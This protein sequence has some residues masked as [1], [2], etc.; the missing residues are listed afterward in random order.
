M[1]KI[2][3]EIK[4]NVDRLESIRSE[5]KQMSQI[6]TN[7]SLDIEVLNTLLDILRKEAH[8]LTLKIDIVDMFLVKIQRTK[9]TCPICQD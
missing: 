6:A 3:N 1:D 9:D 2:I 4:N 7:K 8:A 5:V